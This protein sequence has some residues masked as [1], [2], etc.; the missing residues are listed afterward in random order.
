MPYEIKDE[1]IILNS[2]R[3]IH[4]MGTAVHIDGTM[5][6]GGLNVNDI[7]GNA[8]PDLD[9]LKEIS[10]LADGVAGRYI[11]II[12][13]TTKNQTFSEEDVGSTASNRFVLGV[14]NKSIGINGTVT[15]IY[16]SGLT[17]GGSGSQSRWVLTAST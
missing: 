9:T 11:V 10:G 2:L 1:H 17:V 16:V 5:Y 3:D 6:V 12:N 7:L 4:L 8:P 14:S 13:N 15:L